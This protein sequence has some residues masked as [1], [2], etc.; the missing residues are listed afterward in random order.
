[1]NQQSA[2]RYISSPGSDPTIFF[3]F[4]HNGGCLVEKQQM[5]ILLFLVWFDRGSTA[6]KANTVTKCFS[7]KWAKMILKQQITV[8]RK[9]KAKQQNKSCDNNT[10][11]ILE[12][13]LKSCD[14]NT[15]FILE[16]CLKS[17]DNNT[18]FILETC[19]KSSDKNFCT[20]VY[21]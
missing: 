5:R 16:T 1:M 18:T 8:Q 3:I 4:L 11:F 14:N 20:C 21:K 12:T 17:C 6:L 2:G 19:L 10:T 9:R 15:T 7:N 13:C